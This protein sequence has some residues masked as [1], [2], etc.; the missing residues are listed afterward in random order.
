M[1]LGERSG[2]R[3]WRDWPPALARRERPRCRR[4]RARHAERIHFWRSASG[5]SSAS[6]S[7]CARYANERGVRIVGDVPIFVAHHSADVWAQPELFELDARRAGRPSSPA[8]RPTT[9]APPASAGATRSTAGTRMRRDGY[10]LVDRAHPPHAWRC[11]DLVRIDHFRGFAGYWEVAGRR[12]DRDQ[13]PLGA[14]PG[15]GALR[16]DRARR[17]G[18]AADHRRGPRRDHARR[19]RAAQA[20][21]ASPACGCC[22][23]PSAAT[24]ARTRYLPHNYEPDTRAST[25]ARTTTTPRVGWWR[26]GA[27]RARARLAFGYL[28][29]DAHDIHWA[30]DPRGLASVARL[31]IY[32]L[33][34][35]LGLGSEHRMNVPGLRT[36]GP[37]A[38]TGRSSAPS[39]TSP[40]AERRRRPRA[41]RAAA[42]AAVS[43]GPADALGAP[44]PR[45]RGSE[46][47]RLERKDRAPARPQAPLAGAPR[48]SAG[49][50]STP[51]RRRPATRRAGFSARRPARPPRW[52]AS[53]CWPAAAPGSARCRTP[54]SHRAR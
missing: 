36:A 21:S 50:P 15:R 27:S 5:A 51:R 31:A 17:S 41:D 52:S 1:A 12:A 14:G 48:R 8:C 33:Q 40:R 39:R 19:R 46:R 30:P 29:P 16:R 45:D 4:P 9:S 11:V 22:S 6:G 43:G 38:S 34:D 49:A 25:P 35:V 7:A 42:P 2:G 32:P 26:H 47:R 28:Q 10:A 20:A 18:D 37:G 23:S 54:E 53:A 3:D 44:G 13:R 24:A